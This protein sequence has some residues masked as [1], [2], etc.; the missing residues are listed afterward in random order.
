MSDRCETNS[1]PATLRSRRSPM[2]W[3]RH[4]CLLLFV[5]CSMV[6]GCGSSVSAVDRNDGGGDGG[7]RASACPGPGCTVTA[8]G[9][10]ACAL[11]FACAIPS[12]G[13]Q[14]VSCGA[15]T[16]CSG[17]CG[18]SCDVDCSMGATCAVTVG[19]SSSS[20]CDMAHCTVVAGASATYTGSQAATCAVTMGPSSSVTCEGGS[21]CNFVCTASCGLECRDSS[22]C[23]VRCAGDSAARSF[24]G[25][26]T[27]S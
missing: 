4:S 13:S 22:V 1:R 9:A 12:G 15:G 24:T 14:H 16:S 18:S 25:S 27:C 17:T 26:T 21:T 11:G 7:L 23:T 20:S 19:D 6:V 5:F 10:L 8:P 3:F 2:M